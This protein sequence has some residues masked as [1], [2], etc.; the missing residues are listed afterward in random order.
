M[1]NITRQ[2]VDDSLDKILGKERKEPT[3]LKC[4]RCKTTDSVSV[5]E[6]I[7]VDYPKGQYIFL[8][9]KCYDILREQEFTDRLNNDPRM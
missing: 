2:R 8:C 9:S 5:F 4:K 3:P 1:E 7:F 6:N